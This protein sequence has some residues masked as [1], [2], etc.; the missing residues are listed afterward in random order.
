MASQ[1]GR[2][3]VLGRVALDLPSIRKGLAQ[4][5]QLI[6]PVESAEYKAWRHRFVRERLPLVFWLVVACLLTFIALNYYIYLSQ[7]Q[8]YIKRQLVS[9]DIIRAIYSTTLL[10][11]L[12]C[13][14]LYRS[15]FGHRYPEAIF[16]GLSWSTTMVSQLVATFYGLPNADLIAWTLL[17][18]AQATFM[19]VRWTWICL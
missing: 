14:L 10:S 16:L 2:K 9:Y 15:R 5:W 8:N 7:P 4:L 19:P 11:V 17:F 6:H 12:A 1:A 13:L 18:T 3:G